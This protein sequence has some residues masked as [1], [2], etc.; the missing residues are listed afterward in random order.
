MD[1]AIDFGCALEGGAVLP[2]T[3]TDAPLVSSTRRAPSELA[4]ELRAQLRTF[5]P[6][7]RDPQRFEYYARYGFTALSRAVLTQKL[8]PGLAHTALLRYG[9][10]LLEL[11]PYL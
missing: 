3:I 5:P 1:E 6:P 9:E 10:A 7:P 8:H 4:D 2:G 11:A